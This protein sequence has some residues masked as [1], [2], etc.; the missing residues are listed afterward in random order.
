MMMTKGS[1]LN[2]HNNEKTWRKVFFV[3]QIE[4]KRA[5]MQ[6]AEQLVATKMQ[7]GQVSAEHKPKGN[8]VTARTR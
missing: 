7:F 5:S 6:L 1:Y 2:K 3:V 8:K 4:K